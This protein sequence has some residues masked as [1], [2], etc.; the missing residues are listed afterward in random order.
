MGGLYPLVYPFFSDYYTPWEVPP[1][2]FFRFN[3]RKGWENNITRSF[4]EK[5]N[6]LKLRLKKYVK[7]VAIT[8]SGQIWIKAMDTF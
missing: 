5:E 7:K 4:Q 2:F 8:P 3:E 1:F 6:R